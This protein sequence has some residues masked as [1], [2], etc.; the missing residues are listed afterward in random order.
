MENIIS[1]SPCSCH[2]GVKGSHWRASAISPWKAELSALQVAQPMGRAQTLHVQD[3]WPHWPWDLGKSPTPT[4]LP[5][6][7]HL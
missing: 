7:P 2:T 5:R 4:P 6:F 3:S 1:I